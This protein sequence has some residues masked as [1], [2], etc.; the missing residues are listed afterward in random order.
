[1]SVISRS[2]AEAIARG[3][4]GGPF[5]PAFDL[6]TGRGWYAAGDSVCYRCP[7]PGGGE[8][9]VVRGPTVEESSFHFE[10]GGVSGAAFSHMSSAEVDG[11]CLC[12]SWSCPCEP[13]GPDGRHREAEG[14]ASFE[15]ARRGGS[16]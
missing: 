10:C 5:E 12:L 8:L 3:F 7:L 1:M 16:A 15:I 14:H 4:G 6:S 13:F 9:T 2:D 11:D